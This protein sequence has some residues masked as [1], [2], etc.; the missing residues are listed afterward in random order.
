MV[1]FK[2]LINA[3]QSLRV[4]S[5][6]PEKKIYNTILSQPFTS[7]IS[8]TFTANTKQNDTLLEETGFLCFLHFLLEVI[9]KSPVSS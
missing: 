1:N 3:Y 7:D 4:E 9:Q 2:I 8:N 5:T 6:T